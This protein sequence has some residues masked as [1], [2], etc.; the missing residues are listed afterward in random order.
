MASAKSEFVDI[1]KA[2][3]PERERLQSTV[4]VTQRMV[5]AAYKAVL[6]K[7]M[8]LYELELTQPEFVRM[9]LV[10]E[11]IRVALEERAKELS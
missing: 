4:I 3:V 10:E 7:Q 11:C 5:D 2:V 9:L 1:P 8:K 6:I